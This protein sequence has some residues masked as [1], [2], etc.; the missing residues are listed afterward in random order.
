M[1]SRCRWP[2]AKRFPAKPADIKLRPH[3]LLEGCEGNEMSNP[4]VST[5]DELWAQ[6]A[7]DRLAAYRRG[8]LPAIPLAEVLA[9]YAIKQT[10]A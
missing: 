8:E 3:G 9:K 7:E 6:E 5:L 4:P 1:A 2:Q 10:D